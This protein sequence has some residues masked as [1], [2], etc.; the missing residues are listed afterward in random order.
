[1]SK[2][3]LKLCLSNICV[4]YRYSTLW[5]IILGPLKTLR[6]QILATS[7]PWPTEIFGHDHSRLKIVQTVVLNI[8]ETVAA[9][10]INNDLVGSELENFTFEYTKE[11][12]SNNE[13]IYSNVTGA[14]WFKKTQRAVRRKWGE[15]VYLLALDINSDK[16]QADRL[17]AQN[18]WPCN[19]SIA[20]LTSAVRHSDKGSDIVGYCP[21]LPY[22]RERMHELLTQT[23][24]VRRAWK[25]VYVTL[26]R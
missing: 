16:T 22:S 11:F 7:I 9:L 15:N 4:L 8:V 17:H 2:A 10:L 18:F 6:P 20:N 23:Y 25:T 12:N 5:D 21:V 3:Y 24:D 19:V 14:N 26:K 13:R 1:M